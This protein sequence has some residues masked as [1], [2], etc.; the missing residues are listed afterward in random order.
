LKSSRDSTFTAVSTCLH[1]AADCWQA[2][3]SGKRHRADHRYHNG[4]NRRAS[5]DVPV[6]RLLRLLLWYVDVLINSE[7]V[8]NNKSKV[9]SGA[10]I[11]SVLVTVVVLS[12]PRP[13]L[14]HPCPATY[15]YIPFHIRASCLVS[16]PCPRFFVLCVSPLQAEADLL[17]TSRAQYA[18]TR[19]RY[20]A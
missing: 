15:I 6:L 11:A 18:V 12:E 10:W 17:P 1:V 9:G 7:T 3:K 5:G 14:E 20:H 8:F 19:C 16:V 13:R 4:P 2:S